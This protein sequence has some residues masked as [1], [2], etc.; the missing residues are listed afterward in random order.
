MALAFINPDPAP[1]LAIEALESR[2]GSRLPSPFRELLAAVSN[3][4]EVE[5]VAAQSASAVGVV[6]VLGAGRG[7][8]FDLE[9]RADQ[10]RGDRLPGGL[11]PVADAEGGNLVC[12]SLRP[13]DFGTVWFWDHERELA[14]DA[15]VQVA[16][17]FDE[18]LVD[19]APISEVEE[20]SAVTEA[21]IDP[22][23]L[24]ELEDDQS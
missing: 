3:G 18:F 10:Y 9:T 19:L 24:A 5:P 22:A 23:L 14:G 15:A 13:D 12:L 7:D 6:A 16:A 8:H 2:L 21:W 17:N 1:I 20:P 4:G 11:I